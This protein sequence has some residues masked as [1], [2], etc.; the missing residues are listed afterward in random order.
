MILCQVQSG[1]NATTVK[2]MMSEI[3]T[4]KDIMA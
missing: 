4:S 2:E 1:Y 3:Y